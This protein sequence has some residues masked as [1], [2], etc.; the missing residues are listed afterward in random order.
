MKAKSILII[1]FILIVLVFVS[2]NLFPTPIGPHGGIVK[3]AGGYNIEM[4]SGYR[5]IYTYLL[6]GKQ[7]SLSNEGITCEVCYIFPDSTRI[8]NSLRP[9][10][11]DGFSSHTTILKFH[12][13]KITFNVHGKLVSAKFE[14]DYPI[15]N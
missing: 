11:K 10:G 4:V 8:T 14:N 12:S 13:L 2:M 15:V 7:R 1:C 3:S 6:D 9:Y 5:D